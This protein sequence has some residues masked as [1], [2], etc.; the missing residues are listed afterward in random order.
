MRVGTGLGVGEGVGLG[1]CWGVGDG[2][3]VAVSTGL[4]VGEGTGVAVG[5]GVQVAD[6]AQATVGDR[7]SDTRGDGDLPMHPALIHRRTNTA[8]FGQLEPAFLRIIPSL[9]G[10]LASPV[11]RWY[12]RARRQCCHRATSRQALAFWSGDRK[13][14]VVWSECSGATTFAPREMR[15][16]QKKGGVDEVHDHSTRKPACRQPHSS[17]YRLGK[18]SETLTRRSGYG[19]ARYGGGW[20]TSR[21]GYVPCSPKSWNASASVGWLHPRKI[22]V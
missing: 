2:V 1:V 17:I 3:R 10:Q 7:I 8:I 20:N 18:P 14:P 21:R 5:Q 12:R 4:T 22:M 16:P 11:P 15:D 19:M 13:R 6:V 9:Q